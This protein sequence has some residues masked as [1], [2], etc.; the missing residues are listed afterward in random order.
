VALGS[1]PGGG[2]LSGTVFLAAVNGVA[3]FSNLSID[4]AGTGYTLTASDG[5]LAGATS[6]AFNI[7]PAAAAQVAFTTQPHGTTAGAFITPA[8]QVAVEDA[9][10]NVVTT[11]TSNIT[12]AIGSNPSGGTLSG[13]T[14]MAAVSGVATFGDL[15]INKAGNNYTLRASDGSLTAAISD[16]FDIIPAGATQLA[17][18]QQPSNTTAG[19]LISPAVRV[20]IEDQFGNVVTG[21]NSTVSVAIASNPGGGTLSGTTTVTAVSGVATF[22]NLS[23]N[24]AGTGYTLAAS[25]GAL[26]GATSNAF[27]ITPAA[28]SQVVF[29]TQPSDTAAGA[30]ITPA[31]RVA[32]EDQFGN[33]VT[34][35][36]S[37]VTVAIGSNPSGGTLSGT[38]TRAAVSGVATFNNLSINRAGAGYTLR[39]SDGSLTGSFSSAFNIIR[40]AALLDPGF[41][42]PNVGTGTFGAFQYDPAASPWTFAGNAG[43]AGNGSG[44]TGS[45]P[46]APQGTQVGF[47]QTFGSTSQAVTLAAGTYGISFFAAQ[48]N[49]NVSSQTFQVLVDGN[50]VDSF[51]P[52]GISYNAYTTRKFVEAAGPHTISFAGTDPDGQDNTAFLDQVRI[53]QPIANFGFEQPNVG[54]GFQIDPTGTPITYTG[55]AGVAGNGS[56]LGNPTAPEGTQV[57]FLQGTGSMSTTG[58]LPVGT[59]SISLFAAQAGSNATRQTIQVLVDGNVVGTITPAGTAYAADNTN[60]F[61]ITAGAHTFAIVGTN[62]ADQTSMAFLDLA[63][64][65]QFVAGYGFEQPNVGSGVQYDPT[66]GPAAISYTGTAGVAGNGSAFTAGNPDAPEGTQVGFLQGTGSISGSGNLAA[67]TYIVTLTAA[68]RAANASSQTFQVLVDGNVVGTFTPTGTDYTAFTTIDFTVAAGPHTISFVGLNPHGGDNTVLLDQLELLAAN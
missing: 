26:T 17:F 23:I 24:K 21:N 51:T 32:V 38:L 28:A 11:N 20:A 27:N 3:T 55:T 44:F 48:R 56:A 9:F 67:G 62:L 60:P 45:N 19:A 25:D 57:G 59:Y 42:T 52:A 63:R 7:T 68:Q 22:P 37:N 35:N 13:T 15:S 6:G 64:V 61:P 66:G 43:V 54:N 8:V 10:G 12:V 18:A 4:K 40:P 46:N 2:T 1:N 39:A 58:S 29:I 53:Y 16:P 33:V 41:E 49:G 31:V 5:N 30:V 14:T 50:V 65:N 36:T 47:L 34:G